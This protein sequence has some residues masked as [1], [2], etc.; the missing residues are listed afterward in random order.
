LSEDNIVFVSGKP[1]DNADFSELK[2][3]A[4]EIV[5]LEKVRDYYAKSVNLRLE[6]EKIFPQNIED[7]HSLSKQYPGACNLVFH[8][9]DDNQRKKRILSHNMRVSSSREFL[10]KLRDVY[11]KSNVWVE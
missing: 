10:T 9:N 2:L 3:I 11:G 1:T 7:L 6:L 5:S 8:Y 4:D